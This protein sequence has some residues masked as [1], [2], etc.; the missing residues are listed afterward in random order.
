ML[1]EVGEQVPL[2]GACPDGLSL[3]C[4]FVV[5]L[6]LMGGAPPGDWRGEDAVA[7]VAGIGRARVALLQAEAIKRSRLGGG[8]KVPHTGV[9]WL[10]GLGSSL[11]ASR[12]VRES[13]A[14]T[15]A[16]RPV[17][18]IREGRL[19]QV[20]APA[21]EAAPGAVANTQS[22]RSFAVVDGS[23]AGG[24]RRRGDLGG[25]CPGRR[26]HL[27]PGRMRRRELAVGGH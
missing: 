10:R 3:R 4:S 22:Y 27:L 21:A 5:P 20:A 8:D 7:E 26:S 12:S 16:R 13:S 18:G 15:I 23:S 14:G 24:G 2:G 19:A 6:T 9:S 17:R 11:L 25:S 1:A